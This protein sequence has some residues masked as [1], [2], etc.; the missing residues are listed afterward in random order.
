M[1]T[2][3]KDVKDT[4]ILLQLTIGDIETLRCVIQHKAIVYGLTV[5]ENAVNEKIKTQLYTR[6][7][8]GTK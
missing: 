6:L 8:G 7:C 5:K 4:L 2:P 1:D 3:L